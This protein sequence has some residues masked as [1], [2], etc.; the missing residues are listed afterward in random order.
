MRKQES[1]LSSQA[2]AIFNLFQ[3]ALGPPEPLSE[4]LALE[5]GE[6]EGE[7]VEDDEWSDDDPVERAVARSLQEWEIERDRTPSPCRCNFYQSPASV[8][9]EGVA[10]PAAS[11]EAVPPNFSAVPATWRWMM[12]TQE[13]EGKDIS[14]LRS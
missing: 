7:V 12:R 9:L 8:A 1:R 2:Y 6:S 14:W 4:S 5:Q 13:V 10:T 11:S 3:E